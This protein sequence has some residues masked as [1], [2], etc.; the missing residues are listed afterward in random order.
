MTF[1]RSALG[2]VNTEVDV[3][4]GTCAYNEDDCCDES[5]SIEWDTSDDFVQPDNCNW[6]RSSCLMSMMRVSNTSE[7]SNCDDHGSAEHHTTS[8]FKCVPGM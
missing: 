8:D 4:T 6:N 7:K 3:R 5:E 1:Q 2:Y